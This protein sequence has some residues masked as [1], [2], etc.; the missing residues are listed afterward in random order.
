METGFF[1]SFFSLYGSQ[2]VSATVYQ[3]SSKYEESHTD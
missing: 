2:L 1:S 3:H